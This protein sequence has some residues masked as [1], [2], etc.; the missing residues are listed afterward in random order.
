[1]RVEECGFEKVE[2]MNV[3]NEW[4][5][6]EKSEWMQKRMKWKIGKCENKCWDC[7]CDG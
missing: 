5:L 1:M 6:T 3:L 7:K 2:C 4:W